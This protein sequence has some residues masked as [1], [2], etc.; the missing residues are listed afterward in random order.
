MKTLLL[1]LCMAMSTLWARGRLYH[2][3]V[4]WVETIGVDAG[5]AASGADRIAGA[6]AQ[7]VVVR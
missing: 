4:S 1:L 7:D 2:D 5:S 3:H 6:R